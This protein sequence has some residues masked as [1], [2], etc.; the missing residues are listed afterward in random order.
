MQIYKNFEV[1]HAAGNGLQRS[2]CD[3]DEKVDS[4]GGVIGFDQ[5]NLLVTGGGGNDTT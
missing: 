4:T 2:S 1:Q 3:S 5:H